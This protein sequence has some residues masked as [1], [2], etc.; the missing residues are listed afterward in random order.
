MGPSAGNPL[1]NWLS[2]TRDWPLA[3]RASGLFV[4]VIILGSFGAIVYSG[5]ATP[6][7]QI[8]R[9]EWPHTDFA[10]HSTDLSEIMSGGPPKDGIP[11]IDHPRFERLASGKVAGWLARLHDTEPVISIEIDGD[12]RAYP[13]R[14]LIWHEIVNDTIDG[15]SVVITYCPLCGTGIGFESV[16][17]GR[18][19]TFG[20][21]GLLYQSDLLM[22]DHQTESLWSQIAMEAVAGPMTGTQVKHLFLAHTTWQEWQHEHPSTLVLSTKTGYARDYDRDRYLGYVGRPDI[23]FAINH[24]DRRYHPKE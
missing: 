7:V 15:Q 19:S 6:D 20:V 13:I 23:M 10:K 8:W 1:F 21:S 12:L 16:M 24:V 4:A 2:T 11:A 17:Q 9:A 18:R 14:I 22:Y 3:N 5:A